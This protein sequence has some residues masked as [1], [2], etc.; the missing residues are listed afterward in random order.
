MKKLIL[1]AITA[2]CL[3]IIL[4]SCQSGTFHWTTDYVK[5]SV[6][7]NGFLTEWTNLASSETYYPD[8][9]ESPLLQIRKDSV[10]YQPDN[11]V[12]GE[13]EGLF[14]LSF[15]DLDIKAQI[16]VRAES[17]HIVFELVECDKADELDLIVWGPYANTINQIIGEIVGVVRDSSFAIG[18]QS[19]NIRTLGGF[20]SQ[21]ND[22]DPS[23]DIFETNSLVDVSDSLRVFYRGQTARHTD[24]GSI[25]QAYSRN[26][27][28]ERIISNWNHDYYLAPAFEDK[29]ILGSAIAL[30]GAP[31]SKALEIIGKIEIAEGLPH[32]MIDGAWGKTVRS[33]SASYLIMN[34]GEENLEEAIDLT[35]KAGLKYLYHGGPFVNWGHFD[36]NEKEFP[37]NWESLKA[38]VKKAEQAGIHLG[39]HTLSN[40]ITTNDP[41]VTPVPD[42]RLAKVGS[43]SLA[44]ST[45]PTSQEIEIVDPLFFNQMKNNTLHALMIENEIIRYESVSESAPWILRNCERGAFGTQASA[46]DEGQLISK[47]MD[48]GYRTFLTNADLSKEVALRIADLYNQTG[49]RQISFDGLEGNWS[50][51]MGQYGRQLFVKYWYDALNKDLQGTVITDA[52]NPG[53]YFWHMYTRMNWGE[54]WYAGLR[55]SQTQYRLLNQAL[56]QRNLMPSMLGWFKM[57]NE[58]SLEDIEWLLAR[59]AGFNAGFAL[60]TGPEIVQQHG[61]GALMLETIKIWET[62]RM[63]GAFPDKIKAE[64]QDI[65]QEFHLEKA[66]SNAWQLYK[67]TLVKSKYKNIDKQPGEPNIVKMELNNQNPEQA[68]HLM[69]SSPKE[70]GLQ[71]MQVEI[72]NFRKILLPLDLPPNHHLKYTGGSYV[73]LYDAK[74]NLISTGRIIQDHFILDQGKHEISFN[75]EFTSEG[76]ELSI[77]MRTWGLPVRLS[78]KAE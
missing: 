37:E 13:T 62:A 57:T 18:I 56:F 54:P 26:R 8:Q 31:A 33:A 29:G 78:S 30:F 2:L 36:L 20:P 69:L 65:S 27:N 55:E 59:A 76:G 24:Y 52:S 42:A 10:Y 7:N 22:Q 74:W 5:L 12:K 75:G 17:S 73:E 32:P 1:N 50:T 38:Y 48:H 77:E 16:K 11:M 25:L 71:N 45:S 19:L 15:S 60:V 44:K 58:I 14:I 47:L 61:K 66:G 67:A 43:S 34:F 9:A 41:Y 35:K 39:L 64:L 3:S 46:H 4:V 28:S 63:A 53:H 6:N 21:E 23:Y 72:D 40:F 70:S 49:V 68:L 51:G